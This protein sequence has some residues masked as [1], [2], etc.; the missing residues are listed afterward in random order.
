M[1]NDSSEK[2]HVLAAKKLVKGL[3]VPIRKGQIDSVFGSCHALMTVGAAA[4][5]SAMID[6]TIARIGS[7]VKNHSITASA[8]NA[9]HA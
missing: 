3:N 8:E 9:P 6:R 1:G 2:L 7:L 5:A 4:K